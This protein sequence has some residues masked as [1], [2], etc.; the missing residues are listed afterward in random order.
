MD[1]ARVLI[2]EDQLLTAN[3]LKEGLLKAGY[4]ISGIA[5]N[6]E[7]A[8]EIVRT[9][10]PDFALIDIQLEEGSLDGIATALALLRYKEMPIIYLTANT[11]VFNRAKDTNPTAFLEKPFRIKELLLQIELAIHNFYTSSVPYNIRQTDHLFLPFDKAHIRV[12]KEDICYIKAQRNYSDVFLTRDRYK[13]IFPDK[14]SYSPVLL[15]LNA[16]Y[17]FKH[18]P[19]NFFQ[20]S[21]SIII[22]LNYVDRVESDMIHLEG[23]LL[24]IP[25]GKYK[26]LLE[27]LNTI[28]SR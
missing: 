27:R 25:E 19:A 16:G 17:L 4:E 5:Q 24:P 18:L 28:K 20:L 9:H 3:V 22:N 2:I 15:T 7:E 11:D 1:P 10:N 23:D 8:M 6:Y 13:K 14:N 21:R 26:L 12:P